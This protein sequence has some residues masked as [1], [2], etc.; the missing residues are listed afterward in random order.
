MVSMIVK[1]ENTGRVRSGW[2]RLYTGPHRRPGPNIAIQ[3]GASARFRGF[4]KDRLRVKLAPRTSHPMMMR[5][6]DTAVTNEADR[7][8]VAQPLMK[9]NKMI[10]ENTH[11]QRSGGSRSFVQL[12]FLDCMRR[13]R[14]STSCCLHT[15]HTI[16]LDAAKAVVVTVSR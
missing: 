14:N 10:S 4:S 6:F 1:L 12:R 2:D 13:P 9:P 5:L 7:E 3:T 15:I 8:K 16:D 11:A